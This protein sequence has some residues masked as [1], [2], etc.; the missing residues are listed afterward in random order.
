MSI[1][2][3][4]IGLWMRTNADGYIIYNDYSVSGVVKGLL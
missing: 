2:A 4:M 3:N 1:Q